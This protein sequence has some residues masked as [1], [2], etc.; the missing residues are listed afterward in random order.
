MIHYLRAVFKH[1]YE[2]PSPLFLTVY[3]AE[4]KCI[5]NTKDESDIYYLQLHREF[6][7]NTVLYNRHEQ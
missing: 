4:I 5:L 7:A 6:L 1:V 2:T 3:V